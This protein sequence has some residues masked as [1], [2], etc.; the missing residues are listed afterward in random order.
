MKPQRCLVIADDHPIIRAALSA[1]VRTAVPEALVIEADSFATLQT[2]MKEQAKVDAVLLDLNMPG[3]RGFS[4]LLFLRGDYP[5]V[6]VVVVSG[7]DEPAVIRRALDLGAA[8]FISK[9]ASLE[10]MGEALHAVL[11][12]QV[13]RPPEADVPAGPQEL[14]DRD[15][16]RALAS[17]TPQQSRVLVML[18]DGLLNKQIAH[19]LHITEATV[20]AHVT[21]ILNKLGLH[22]R[23]QAAVL[24]Q[25]LM[26][27]EAESLRVDDVPSGPG[28]EG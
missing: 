22:R 4:S 9:S 1:T 20:K 3:A 5:G 25:R 23:T 6:P 28:D 27:T 2:R 15:R 17:L 13:W 14:Q 24:A 18:A 16:A 7:F 21:A 10:R 11:S 19:E 12:G 26:R 8:G